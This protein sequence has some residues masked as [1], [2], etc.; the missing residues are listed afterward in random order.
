MIGNMS[1][2]DC[3]LR[4]VGYQ[5]GWYFD[6][7]FARDVYTFAQTNGI[8]YIELKAC[9]LDEDLLKQIPENLVN[10]YKALPIGYDEANPNILRVAMVDPMDLNAIDDI[11]IAMNAQVEPLLAME[12]DVMEAIGKY[13]II[14]LTMG[15][16]VQF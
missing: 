10:K 3:T 1:I 12:D 14:L 6:T 2:F 16:R 4:E 13:F 9:K 5:T 7:E 8:D 11:G 15:L